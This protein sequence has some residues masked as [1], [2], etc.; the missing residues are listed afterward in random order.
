MEITI[1]NPG[2]VDQ[3][4]YRPGIL[5]TITL[6]ENASVTFEIEG[7]C[8]I[9]KHKEYLWFFAPSQPLRASALS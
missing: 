1:R 7:P 5:S 2:P 4:V 9:R 6:P 8:A 3:Y